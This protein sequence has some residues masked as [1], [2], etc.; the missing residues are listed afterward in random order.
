MFVKPLEATKKLEAGCDIEVLFDPIQLFRSLTYTVYAPALSPLKTEG[1]IKVELSSEYWYPPVP[2]VAV[3][4]IVPSF[5]PKHETFVVV[6][7]TESDIGSNKVKLIGALK[8]P[9]PS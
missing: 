1:T 4:V 8:Q 5:P 7:P 6:V 9:L 2:P 3:I